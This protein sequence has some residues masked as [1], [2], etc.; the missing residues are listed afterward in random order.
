[1]AKRIILSTTRI[2]VP[3]DL[4]RCA[5]EARRT[6]RRGHFCRQ[7]SGLL[8]AEERIAERVTREVGAPSAAML[9]RPSIGCECVPVA[10]EPQQLRWARTRA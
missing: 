7:R 6:R 1:M 3:V 8:Q 10:V 9:L 5:N 2:G 4:K